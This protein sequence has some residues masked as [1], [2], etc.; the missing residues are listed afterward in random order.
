[1]NLIDIYIYEVTKWLPEKT[2]EEIAEELKGNIL[3]M[4]PENYN[5][6]DI[7]NVLTSLGNPRILAANYS[8]NKRY[9]I[10]PVFYDSYIRFLLIAMSA[11]VGIVFLGHLIGGITD[12]SNYPS[13][14][15][16]FIDIFTDSIVGIIQGVFQVFTW[17]TLTFIF[18]DKM[19]HSTDRIPLVKPK[20]TTDQLT[21]RTA[22]KQKYQIP[23]SEAI[24]GFIWTIVWILVLLFAQHLLGWY[25]TE[26]GK[27]VLKATLFNQSVL[28]TYMPL[29]I[30]LAILEISLAGLK[31]TLGKWTYYTATFYT[32][33]STFVIAILYKML[34]DTSLYNNDF[35]NRLNQ[36]FETSTNG[37]IPSSIIAIILAIVIV[38]SVFD[39]SFAFFKAYKTN[40]RK[41]KK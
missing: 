31:Y 37:T 9:I 34:Y 41:H 32:I 4:L 23:K 14:I 16:F 28:N 26:N 1:M 36:L 6:E 39:C 29:L 13:V 35:I 15:T 7:K 22:Q 25:E 3:D 12:F 10:G 24:F 11:M 33:Q 27:L 40:H 20:W 2:K 30:A 19:A 8:G 21:R 5:E 38:I 18:L 17:V